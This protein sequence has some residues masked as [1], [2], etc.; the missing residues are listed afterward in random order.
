MRIR[1]YQITENRYSKERFIG[2]DETKAA[3]GEP[4]PHH[5]SETFN[6]EVDCKTLEGI[7]A[8]FNTDRPCVFHS[9]SLSVSDIVHI[10]DGDKKGIYFCDSIGF[11]KLENFDAD[12]VE[13][14]KGIRVLAI[15]PHKKPYEALHPNNLRQW[16][17]SVQGFIEV[18][19]PFDD[20]TVFI[21]NE[22]SKL[23]GLEGNR[24]INGYIYC[25]NI[26]IAAEKGD[27]FGDLTDEQAAKYKEMFSQD[28][29]FM[30]KEIADSF[31]ITFY[32]F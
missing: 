3:T 12:S 29:S 31:N 17:M 20:G 8:R 9:H 26:I 24:R 2:Y 11:K 30:Q 14:L 16:Q 28:E 5:Y 25:G 7:Y 27:D 19:Y 10:L 18:T 22:T 21:S 32:T 23:D 6:G 13:P 4:N 1:L 15:E